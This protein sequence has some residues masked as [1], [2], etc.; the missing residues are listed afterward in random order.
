MTAVVLAGVLLV[1]DRLA[2]TLA[3]QAVAS[4][5]QASAELD[6]PPDVDISGFPFLTQAVGGRYAR[7]HVEAADVPTGGVRVAALQADLSG[8]EVPLG[9][10]LTGSVASVPV[11]LLTAE[12]LVSYADLSRQSGA[13]R[14]TVS[15][16]GDRVAVTGSVVVLG[17][18][19]SVTALSSVRL[20]GR[21]IVIRAEQLRVGAE[22]ASAAVTAAVGGKL[23]LR[24]PVGRLPYGLVVTGLQV[25][26]E[27]VALS[28][29]AKNTVLTRSALS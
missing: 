19:L 15:R 17:R 11:G 10:A 26:A 14:L 23:D 22:S 12:A 13:R 4:Q 28:A 6:S 25:G 27:G 2:L 8:L 7:V 3:E 1:G 21:S 24:V 9:D 16:S 29:A 5:L 20:A 18:S